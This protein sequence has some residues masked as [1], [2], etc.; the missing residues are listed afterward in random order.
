[1]AGT[2]ITV[3]ASMIDFPGPLNAIVAMAIATVKATLV[4]LF[5]MHVKYISYKVNLIVIV[6]AVF[7]LLLMF[8]MISI[9]YIGHAMS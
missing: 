4:V 8:G 5:F 9:D 6:A 3:A 1:M 7:W 2:V